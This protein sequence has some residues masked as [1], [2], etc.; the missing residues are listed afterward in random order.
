MSAVKQLAHALID[1][2]PDG[3]SWDD[4]LRAVDEAR[5][6]EAVAA[7]VE[8]ADRGDIATADRVREMFARWGVDA[9]R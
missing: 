2:L 6:R 3:A 4:V 7:G 8:A 5:F 1:T 9:P